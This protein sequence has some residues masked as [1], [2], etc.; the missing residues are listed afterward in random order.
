MK[1]QPN[2]IIS[3]RQGTL[4]DLPRILEIE[5]TSFPDPWPEKTFAA[6]FSNSNSK[7][8]VALSETGIIVGYC[9]FW[10]LGKELEV[11]T[12]AVD[13]A[14]RKHGIG[15]LLVNQI[16]IEANLLSINKVMLE[17]RESN[18]SATSLYK[19]LGFT[20]DSMRKNYYREG[21]NAVLMS[22]SIKN[23]VPK[24]AKDPN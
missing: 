23:C 10:N 15:K 4:A 19:S 24:A 7:S 9:F 5:K 22:R 14:W 2:L 20:V 11:H 18:V 17:V 12:I 8:F 16:I 3:I 21:E 13:T 1:N 6:E